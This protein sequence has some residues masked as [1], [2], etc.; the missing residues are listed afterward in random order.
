MAE[1]HCLWDDECV[2]KPDR[3]TEPFQRCEFY[4]LTDKCVRISVKKNKKKV[5]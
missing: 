4:G 3:V 1:Y 2:D 5:S